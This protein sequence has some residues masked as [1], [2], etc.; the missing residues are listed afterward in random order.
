MPVN[1][2]GDDL[3]VAGCGD[4]GSLRGGLKEEETSLDPIGNLN[5]SLTLKLTIG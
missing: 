5:T 1:F 4:D 2:E 3:E